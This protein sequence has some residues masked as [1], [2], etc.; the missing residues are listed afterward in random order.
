M[1]G[2]FRVSIKKALIAPFIV[3]F[4]CTIGT[5]LWLQKERYN[6]LAQEVSTQQLDSL[7]HNVVQSL[8]RFLERPFSAV[9]TLAHAIEYHHLYDHQ[10]A[11]KLE[12]YL[13]SSFTSL[14]EQVK[15]IDLIGFGSEL[16]DF[17]ALRRV[18][19]PTAS[20][21]FILMAQD[22]LT[23]HQ[24]TVYS[25]HDRNSA[26]DDII[27]HYDPRQR[28]WYQPV[29]RTSEPM[30]SKVY[31]NADEQQD[32]TIS[33]LSPVY[34]KNNGQPSFIGVAVVDVQINTFDRFLQDIRQQ[35]KAQVYIIDAQRKLVAHSARS[36]IVDSH[37]QR[38]TM[39]NSS[40]T[41][42]T[43]L[44]RVMAEQPMVGSRVFSHSV[45]G[46]TEYIMISRYQTA[47]DLDWYVVVAISAAD[48]LGKLSIGS[49][50]T[51]LAGLLLGALGLVL[52]I[53]VINRVT[54]PLTETAKAAKQI[55]TGSWDYPL[56]KT[57]TTSE[58][59]QLVESFSSMRSHLQTSFHALREQLVRDNLTKLYSRQGFIETCNAFPV[60]S[61]GCMI[62][63]GINQ[64][65]DINDSLGH[66]QG[67]I[68]LTII[69]ERLKGWVLLE[70]G[71]LGR[72]AGDEF[73]IYLPDIEPQEQLLY[74][75]RIRQVFSAPF[76]LQGEPIMVAVSIGVASSSNSNCLDTCLR[77]AGIAL[78]HAKTESNRSCIYTPDMAESSRKK[79][80]LLKTLR[81][82]IDHDSFEVHFQPIIDLKSGQTL[83][84]EALLRLRDEQ[85]QFVSPLDF[86]PM[87]ESSGLIQ[88]IGNMM[89]RK[90]LSSI[91]TAIAEGQLA[92]GFHLHINVSV[93]ELVSGSYVDE[94]AEIIALSGFPANQL[95]IEITE[96]RL[97]DNDPVT[98]GNLN[99]LKALGVSIAIDDF[100]TGYSSLAYLHKL[101]FDS[102]K[103]D[104]AFV[105]RLNRDNAHDSVVAAITKL[106][107][108]FGFSLVAEGVE[109]HLQAELVREL[110]CHHAQGYL[111]SAPKPLEEWPQL[112]ATA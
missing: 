58:I 88:T 27:T 77:N 24:L 18:E 30:W 46:D 104:K 81:H 89:A 32:I 110:G 7:T 44:D 29:K 61:N 50:Q 39:A 4:L 102:L 19:T 100:G 94:L 38:L 23:N 8:D 105:E 11:D 47:T 107:R 54:I 71:V 108:S 91:A 86:I 1:T 14:S 26:V 51:L 52:G 48:L 42:L 43:F 67:D 31:A 106:S 12:S 87:A 59:A 73:A 37:G 66:N 35:H 90:A 72:V 62:L 96:S 16:G 55:A 53:A 93:I 2:F 13:R 95:T 56:P 79:T 36:S 92:S 57:R 34:T 112:R 3:V 20:T 33:A 45:Q 25:G 10:E 84:A 85:Q 98:L 63:L 80:K 9:K 70:N 65:R 69:A 75:H 97:A 28:P 68:L 78:S 103:V 109:T 76:V 82:A 6:D 15:H 111:F 21:P 49:E 22:A 64:F 99:Q 5:I 40:H 83:G 101:P 41:T 17:L 74:Q 60:N